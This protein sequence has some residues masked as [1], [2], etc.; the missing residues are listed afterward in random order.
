MGII[1][2]S[3]LAIVGTA[4]AS[5]VSP[6]V[7][8]SAP[9]AVDLHPFPTVKLIVTDSAK[10]VYAKE[11]RSTVEGLLTGWLQS[12]DFA[13]VEADPEMMVN[14]T[15]GQSGEAARIG[16]VSRSLG[17][18]GDFIQNNGHQERIINQGLA[19]AGRIARLV[20]NKAQKES[21]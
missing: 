20:V 1:K 4:L 18:I 17:Q 10:P 7:T 21:Q 15:G 16:L 6:K 13:L 2:F 8:T 12:L 9:A 14:A 19:S 5:Y 11:G 3:L